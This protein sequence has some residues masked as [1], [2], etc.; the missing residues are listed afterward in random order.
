MSHLPD[1]LLQ[2]VI[3]YTM[4][5]EASRISITDKRN[6]TLVKNYY[7]GDL[8]KIRPSLKKWKK[9]FPN[10]KYANIR[11]RL[12][13]KDSDFKYLE[14]VQELNMALCSQRSITDHTFRYLLNIRKLNLQGCCDVWAHHFTDD[15]FQYL[16][17]LEGFYIDHNHVIT[18]AGIQKLT[19]LT[20][21]SIH[22]CSNITNN[23]LA[24]LTNLRKLSIYNLYKLT[25]EVFDNLN[26]EELEMT[27]GQ[28]TDKGL[29]KLM[30]I[31]KMNLISV[32]H[33]RCK[34]FDKLKHLEKLFVYGNLRDEDL[35]NC[36]KVKD[37]QLYACKINGDGLK[38]LVN[39]DIISIYESPITDENLVHLY[40]LPLKKIN[41]YRCNLIT[42]GKK[43]E[44]SSVFGN[45]FQ[46]DTVR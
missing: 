43:D 32:E 9:T 3:N 6:N 8:Y 20:D 10:A 30:N 39:C 17:N 45:K 46:T 41:I 16:L 14:K 22:S 5:K 37:L 7:V 15:I 13:I 44:L 4:K 27:F 31:K 34:D 42:N 29:T 28:I 40:N 21:L 25:D 24:N 33:V 1:E 19:K 23:G 11:E 36:S 12:C 38:Y 35:R 2:I 26:L 18:D